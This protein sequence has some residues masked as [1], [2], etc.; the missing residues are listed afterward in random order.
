M[1]PQSRTGFNPVSA[2]DQ[3]WNAVVT[4][5]PLPDG[6]RPLRQALSVHSQH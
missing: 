5:L 2:H 6:Y 1:K 4:A 3:V